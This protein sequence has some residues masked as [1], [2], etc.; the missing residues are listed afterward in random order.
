MGFYEVRRPATTSDFAARSSSKSI[1]KGGNEFE[2]TA[3]PCQSLEQVSLRGCSVS[4]AGLASLAT[5]C[6]KLRVIDVNV[7]TT[8]VGGGRYGGG[9]GSYGG[10]VTGAGIDLLTASYPEIKIITRPKYDDDD[11]YCYGCDDYY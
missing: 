11:D 8:E 4:D 3:Q 2:G 7:D 6:P 1:S 9:D 5:A 10:T